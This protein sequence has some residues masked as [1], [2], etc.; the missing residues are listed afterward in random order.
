[1]S[2]TLRA[3]SDALH[4]I[5]L[6]LLVSTFPGKREFPCQY[7][8]RQNV[9]RYL[10]SSL[11]AVSVSLATL[12]SFKATR[13][14]VSFS[15]LAMIQRC[16]L[17]VYLLTTHNRPNSILTHR[18][19]VGVTVYPFQNSFQEGETACDNRFH[20]PYFSISR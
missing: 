8:D 14:L 3:R 11:P 20:P 15:P 10:A 16:L 2:N 17:S 19:S 4:Y 7:D 18:N 9:C 13:E 1:M 5:A 12:L 6:E